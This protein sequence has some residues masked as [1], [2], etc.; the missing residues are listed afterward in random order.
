MARLTGYKMR[1]DEKR[2]YL[3]MTQSSEERRVMEE[4]CSMALSESAAH[5]LGGSCGTSV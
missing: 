5:W 4:E 2:R 1:R 3:D